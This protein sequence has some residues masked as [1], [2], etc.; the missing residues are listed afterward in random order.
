MLVQGSSERTN[1]KKKQSGPLEYIKSSCHKIIRKAELNQLSRM[2]E[3]G[4][5]RC[6]SF[7]FHVRHLIVIKT[8]RMVAML[9]RHGAIHKAG[10]QRQSVIDVREMKREPLAPLHTAKPAKK[11]RSQYVKTNLYS[12]RHD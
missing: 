5:P 7:V 2:A 3:V 6:I 4:S 11:E 1:L 10:R 12:I 8:S 9:L